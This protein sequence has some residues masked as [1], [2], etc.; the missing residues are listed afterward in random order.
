MEKV[1]V[2]N[3]LRLH[4]EEAQSLRQEARKAVAQAKEDTQNNVPVNEIHIVVIVDFYQNVQLPSHKKDQPRETYF[5]VPLNIYV[6]G[7]VDCNG[8]KSHLHVYMYTEAEGD[9]DA[10]TV[11][12]LIM[13]YLFE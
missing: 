11:A 13:I 2:I 6:L 4:I 5:F 3:K 9:K 8:G 7:V 12:S 10:N 1:E